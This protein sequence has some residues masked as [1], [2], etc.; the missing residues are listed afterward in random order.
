[1]P[2]QLRLRIETRGFFDAVR[3]HDPVGWLAG[4]HHWPLHVPH[5][6]GRQRPDG[7]RDPTAP[8]GVTWLHPAQRWRRIWATS[9]SYHLGSSRGGQ[10]SD[11]CTAMQ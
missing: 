10:G 6:G 4:M 2:T 11:C 8:E 3:L 9:V 7:V 1:M 5:C